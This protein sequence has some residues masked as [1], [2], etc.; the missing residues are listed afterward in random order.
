V[1]DEAKF[2]SLVCRIVEGPPGSTIGQ[3]RTVVVAAGF[4]KLIS[5]SQHEDRRK[6]MATKKKVSKKKVAKKKVAKKKVAKKK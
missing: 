4:L 1:K 5:G 3:R 2:G 6:Y